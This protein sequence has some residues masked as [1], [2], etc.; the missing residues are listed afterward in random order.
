MRGGGVLV[1]KMLN[2][3]R[4]GLRLA[5]LSKVKVEFVDIFTV[6]ATGMSFEA[7]FGWE[8]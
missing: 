5:L 8:A 3:Y 1:Q 2:Q 6:H 4:A 7:I